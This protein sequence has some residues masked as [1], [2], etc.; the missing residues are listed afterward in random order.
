MD[1]PNGNGESRLDRLEGL[2]KL[3]I[4]D[5]LKFGDEHN[6]LLTSQVLLTDDMRELAKAQKL[7]DERMK[8]LAES[9]RHT[10]E[11]MGVLIHMMDEFIRKRGTDGP[12]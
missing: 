11:R 3:L 2:M 12:G 10:D 4:D 5:H 7:T 8:E 6:K 9:L 1:E